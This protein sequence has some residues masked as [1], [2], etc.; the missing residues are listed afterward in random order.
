MKIS[1]LA[2]PRAKKAGVKKIDESHFEVSITAPA[3]EGRA[4]AAVIRAMADYFD[5]APSRVE[6][7]SGLKG[8]RKTLIILE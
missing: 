2:R 4:N 3:H 6:I 7:V 5:I 1:V 8:K